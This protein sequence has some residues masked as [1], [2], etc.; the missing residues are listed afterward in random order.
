MTDVGNMR[1]RYRRILRFAGWQLTQT[2]WFELFLPRIGLTSFYGR[3]SAEL[4]QLLESGS[5]A[6][7]AA[8]ALTG[9]IFQA[10]TLTSMSFILVPFSAGSSGRTACRPICPATGS[11]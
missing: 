3:Q 10:V 6:W 5:L 1:A 9:P 8:G 2:W 4:S 11:R 7:A